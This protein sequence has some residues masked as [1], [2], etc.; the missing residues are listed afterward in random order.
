MISIS[1][2]FLIES[3]WVYFFYKRR[4]VTRLFWTNCLNLSLGLECGIDVWKSNILILL[5]EERDIDCMYSNIFFIV[6]QNMADPAKITCLSGHLCNL[7][8]Q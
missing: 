6:L 5:Q 2:N 7:G 8:I 3:E 1:E 4:S